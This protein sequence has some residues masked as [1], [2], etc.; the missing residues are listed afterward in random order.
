MD[1]REGSAQEA[2]KMGARDGKR[3]G[4]REYARGKL[5]WRA[6]GDGQTWLPAFTGWRRR[7]PAEDF[8]RPVGSRFLAS[9]SIFP[10][11]KSFRRLGDALNKVL[12]ML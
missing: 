1:E 7:K 3:A 6:G 9:F 12:E 2:A 11:T 5:R 4:E 10:D 8:R